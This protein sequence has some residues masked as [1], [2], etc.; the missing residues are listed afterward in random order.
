MA[1]P[2]TMMLISDAVD[3]KGAPANR[4]TTGG[5]LSAASILG[6]E[7][8]ERLSTMAIGVNLVTYLR[9]TMHLPSATSSSIVTNWGGISFL[10]SLFGGIL[11]D[12]FLGRYWT[13]T[14]FAN[15]HVLGS[16]LLAI[17]TVVPSFRPPPCNPSLPDDCE[18]ANGVQ[19]LVFYFAIYAI[20]VGLGG[21]K[22]CVS[23]FGTDQFD[24]KDDKEKSQMAYFFNRFYFFISIGTLIAVT[25]FIYIQDKVARVWGYG[26]C[27]VMMILSI[28]VFVSGTRRYRYKKCLGSPI[29]QIMQVLVAAFIKRKLKFPSNMQQLHEI[30]SEDSKISRTT[31]FR[32]LDKAAIIDDAESSIMIESGSTNPWRLCSV[33]KVEEVKMMTRILP[34]WAT[35]IMFYVIHAQ[36]ITF[37]VLQAATMKRSIG[38]FQI[39]AASFNAFFIAAILIT[40]GIYDRLVIPLW[41]KKKSTPG[42]TSFQKMGI[43]LFISIITMIVAVIVEYRRLKVANST[44]DEV[45]TLPISGFWLV[46]QFMLAGA[47]EGL[48]YTGQLDFFLTE[49]PKGMK[50]LSTSLFLT[51]IAFGF[52]ISSA[53]T[54]IVRKVTQ[55]RHDWLPPNIN[56]GRL[57]L[58]YGCIAVLSF[59]NLVL[60]LWSAKWFVRKKTHTLN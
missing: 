19:M 23:G 57:D 44:S 48:L 32:C 14:I 28:V 38:S 45:L 54:A 37:A 1:T 7:L 41:K 8:C 34:I 12:S 4:S 27:T 49:S 15:I 36:M 22:S 51:T 16:C 9:G 46:P 47:A 3:Y 31:Q 26:S 21:I 42:L 40:L 53:L 24:Q 29:V 5:W 10:L 55:G 17:S 58:F 33:T 56:Q 39:P 18:E 25:V 2:T 20:A 35:T 6:V 60:Y 13:I 59:I 43:G 50:A 30:Y 52:F 11:A